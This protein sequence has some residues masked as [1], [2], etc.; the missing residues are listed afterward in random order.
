MAWRIEEQ[1]IRGEIDN[2]TPGRVI[3][4]IWFAGREEAVELELEGNPWRDLAGHVLKF[5]NPDPKPDDGSRISSYQRG[6]VGDMTAS[7]KV[8]VPDCSM[9]EL[10]EF[11][12]AK[13]PFPWHWGNSLYLEW[14]SDTN[15]RVVIEAAHYQLEVDAEPSWI[16]SEQD[17]AARQSL[18][19][20]AMAKF[21]DRIGS[22]VSGAG[23]K[24]AHED[25]DDDLPQSPEEAQ[26]D[27]EDEKMQLLLDRV[28][29]RLER[30]EFEI[31]DFDRIL[32]EE[33]ARL[34]REQG[35]K[36][37]ELTP[38]QVE[39]RRHWIDEMNSIAEEA[40]VDLEAEKW[41][42]PDRYEEDR[43]PLV[44]ECSDFAVAIHHEIHNAGWLPE[45]AQEEHPLWEI[46]NGVTSASA[47]LAGAVGISS[48]A[49][50][51]PPDR[52]IAGNV[53]VRLKKARGYLRDALQGL[54]CA[55]EEALATPQW[56]HQTRMKVIDILAQTQDLL[57]EAR[58]V[59]AEPGDDELGLF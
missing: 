11:Y 44:V 3:G 18:N 10:M 4:R 30:G 41:K 14:F 25:G 9:E 53:V 57:R 37:P 26:A 55:E 42:G 59:L 2:R 34:R 38:E 45:D 49:D 35:E 51:W 5:T 27:A 13:Q 33:R 24:E 54:D 31:Y 19:A 36:D 7:R 47:K 23:S 8:K 16:P 1:V 50:E 17:E 40:L 22:A 58:D 32:A 29:A 15:G 28:T 52:M 20:E 39:E 56:R 43:H 12:S 48:R 46:Q 21:M 6:V